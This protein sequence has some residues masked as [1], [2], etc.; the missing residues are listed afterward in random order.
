MSLSVILGSRPGIEIR[1]DLGFNSHAT[2]CSLFEPDKMI[3]PLA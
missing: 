1:V 2:S 3:H